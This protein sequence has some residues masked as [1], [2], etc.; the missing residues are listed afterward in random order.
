MKKLSQKDLITKFLFSSTRFLSWMIILLTVFTLGNTARA[1]YFD[2]TFN[3]SVWSWTPLPPPASTLGSTTTS[4]QITSGGN[5]APSRT[6]SHS[7]VPGHI[8]VAHINS[9]AVYD[10]SVQGAITSL[11]YSYDLR[12]YSA[13]AAGAGV[14]FSIAIYQNGSYYRSVPSNTVYTNVWQ[15][16]S[17]SGLSASSFI[18]VYGDSPN[19]NPDFSCNGSKMQLGYLTANTS[20]T[21]TSRRAGIDNWKINIDE[22]KSCSSC[23]AIS[24]QKVICDKGAFTYTFT[25]TNNSSQ[26]IQY[27]LLSPPPGATYTISPNVINLG[28]S[29]LNPGQS[30]TVSVTIGNA[31]PGDNICINVALAD[32]S[33]A[34]CCTIQTC[35][36]L[37]ECPCLKTDYNVK[38]AGNG[39]YTL[40]VVIQNQTSLPI[41]Q[42][43]AVATSPASLNISPQ[44]VTLPTPLLPGQATTITLTLSGVPP[45]QQV[46]L[47]LTPLSETKETCCS[48][49]IC[50]FL[51]Q[52]PVGSVKNNENRKRAAAIQMRVAEQRPYEV[53]FQDVSKR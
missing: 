40:T 24:D 28:G 25:V 44:V 47:Q 26:I 39:S 9:N 22:K 8:Q 18:R 13:A 36:K 27:L 52:C 41:Q 3:N 48:V 45:A 42:V 11:S 31:S 38:C 4:A 10:P 19:E 15:P 2:G 6:T 12:H 20:T 35:V 43:F 37:P 34:V 46:C 23:G 16:F 53:V 29:P 30:T 21:Q 51:P 7:L 1:Q 32:K 14:D 49:R 5:P 33:L 17:G 50:V